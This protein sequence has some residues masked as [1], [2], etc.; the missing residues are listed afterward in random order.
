MIT[1]ESMSIPLLEVLLKTPNYA[2]FMKEIIFRKRSWEMCHL[3]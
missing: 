1:K 3:L 2:K